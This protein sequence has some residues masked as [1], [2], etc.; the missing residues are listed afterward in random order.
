MSIADQT[1]TA[2]LFFQITGFN[3]NTGTKQL[4]VNISY[5]GDNSTTVN[6]NSGNPNMN[7]IAFGQ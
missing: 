3:Y 1:A 5:S 6:T 2:S 4:T 7:L